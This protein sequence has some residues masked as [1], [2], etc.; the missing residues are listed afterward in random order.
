M[1]VEFLLTQE[2][3]KLLSQRRNI[4]SL[5][6]A[7]S[8]HGKRNG[9]VIF[10]WILINLHLSQ[11]TP[12]NKGK[13]MQTSLHISLSI[14]ECESRSMDLIE[15]LILYLYISMGKLR[16]KLLAKNRENLVNRTENSCGERSFRFLLK[17]LIFLDFF[18]SL[19]FVCV[20]YHVGA[21][22]CYPFMVLQ[23]CTSDTF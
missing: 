23:E 13:G 2:P 6:G 21:R 15:W 12:T 14:N 22:I 10:L 7:L 16:I 11:C 17:S 5:I 9:W 8:L 19:R 4:F 20:L 3:T 1:I 18:Y